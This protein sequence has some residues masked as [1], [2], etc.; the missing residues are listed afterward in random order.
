VRKRTPD[1]RTTPRDRLGTNA[2]QYATEVYEPYLIPF[3]FSLDIHIKE[4]LVLDD[5][6]GYHWAT[7][8]STYRIT[9]YPLRAFCPDLNP[10]ENAWHILKSRLRKGF[11][12]SE[13]RC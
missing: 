1:E 6:V 4:I 10:I 12:R 2:T 8:T 7:L 13:L 9:K 11:T 3:L 5:N